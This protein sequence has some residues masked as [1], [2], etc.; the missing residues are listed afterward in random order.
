MIFSAG[1]SC[2]AGVT[3]NDREALVPVVD[4]HV[5]VV[6][7]GAQGRQGG[8]AAEVAIAYVKQHAS[9][10]ASA[11]SCERCV[12]ALVAIDQQIH[13]SNTGGLTT[14]VLVVLGA[15]G[16]VGASVG[17]S[18]AHL[19]G[20]ND[21]VDLTANQARRPFLGSGSARPVCFGPVGFE[22]RLLVAT[23]GLF[24]YGSVHDRELIVRTAS[25]LEVAWRLVDS[26]RLP[27]GHL[28]DDTTVYVIERKLG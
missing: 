24:K 12:E 5:L 20:Q 15:D 19:I 22:G 3:G 14:A 13:A 23:D 8:A 11:M 17:D 16:L 26:V 18:E 4:R 7:D 28:Q 10:I 9:E 1:T 6:A 27:S 21:F 2:S 25:I